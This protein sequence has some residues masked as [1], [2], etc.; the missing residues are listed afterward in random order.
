MKAFLPTIAGLVLPCMVQAVSEF[1]E[2]CYLVCQSQIDKVVLH[3]IDAAVQQFHDAWEIFQEEGICTDFCLPQQHSI[4]H[5]WQ[6]IQMFG[7]PNGLC[8]SITESKHIKAVKQLWCCS[9]CNQL[10][11]QM[12]LTNQCLNKLAALHVELDLCGMLKSASGNPMSTS[13]NTNLALAVFSCLWESLIVFAKD[14]LH[15]WA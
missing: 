2:F 3:K 14:W 13:G 12:L 1:M 4:T 15:V 5:Y 6:Q 11:G 10:L 9:N 7:T 8:S